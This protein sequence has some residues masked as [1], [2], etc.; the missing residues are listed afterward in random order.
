MM[1]TQ[2]PHLVQHSN[3]VDGLRE[4][5][6]RIDGFINLP[7]LLQIEVLRADNADHISQT[8]TIDQ[9]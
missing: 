6:H 5:E 1:Y 7:V 2:F 9:N 8:P 4:I 3:R